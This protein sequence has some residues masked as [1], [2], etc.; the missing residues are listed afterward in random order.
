MTRSQIKIAQKKSI[1]SFAIDVVDFMNNE[2]YE[3]KIYLLMKETLSKEPLLIYSSATPQLVSSLQA[4]FPNVSEELEK[5]LGRIA[6][7]AYEYNI[8]RFIIAGGESSGAVV[9]ALGISVVKIGKS[10]APGVPWI[11]TISEDPTHLTLKSG[12]FG[13]QEFF[14]K[15]LE[16]QE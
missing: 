10:I 3:E 2:N 13:D 5:L 11:S 6:K 1:K 12:N 16:M 4:Q 9:Q 8:R 14:I 7:K 15:S